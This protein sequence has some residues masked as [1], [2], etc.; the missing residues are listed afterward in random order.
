[1]EQFLNIKRHSR[2]FKLINFLTILLFFG[3]ALF[4]I[5]SQNKIFQK[6]KFTNSSDRKKKL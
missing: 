6:S 3:Q 4:I 2:I 1:M 5:V